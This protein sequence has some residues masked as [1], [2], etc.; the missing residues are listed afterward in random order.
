MARNRSIFEDISSIPAIIG[1]QSVGYFISFP[2]HIRVVSDRRRLE[3]DLDRSSPWAYFDG[4]AQNNACG[5]GAVLYLTESHFFVLSMG[6]GEGT[7]NYSELMSLK[8]LLLF[9]LEKGCNNLNIMGDS[10]NVI[11]W[12]NETQECRQLR[13]AHILSA[14]RLLIQCFDSFSC[15]HVYRENNKEADKASKEGL[16]LEAGSWT[17]KEVLEGISQDYYHRPFIEYF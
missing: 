4:V 10:M 6:L 8:L 1:A 7:N 17:V 2:E 3:V 9:S 12:I 14:I 11:N 16:R 5:G 13:L 15:W